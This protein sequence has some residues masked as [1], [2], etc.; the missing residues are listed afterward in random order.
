MNTTERKKAAEQIIQNPEKYKICH[1]CDSIIANGA[2][3][4]PNCHS[5]KFNNSFNDIIDHATILGNKEQESVA[6]DDL[7]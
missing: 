7:Y 4:C 5:Y 1:G 3:T 6:P 2:R